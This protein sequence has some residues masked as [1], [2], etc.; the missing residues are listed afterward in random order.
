MK[1]KTIPLSEAFAKA[2]N[3]PLRQHADGDKTYASLR[4]LEGSCIADCGSR[5]DAIAQAN[6]ALL[7]HCFNH[8][9]EVVAALNKCEDFIGMEV[10]RGKL[11][12]NPFS[13]QMKA[14]IA[15]RKA[16]DNVRNVTI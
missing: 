15:A 11:S 2:S 7:A 8:F 10:L 6:A 1:N 14:L 13:P 3:G 4:C 16:L 5:S 12:D 9:Q